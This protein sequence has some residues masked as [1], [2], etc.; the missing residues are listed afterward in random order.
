[1]N[2]N[3]TLVDYLHVLHGHSELASSCITQSVQRQ[4]FTNKPGMER[5]L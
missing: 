3:V 4:N 2:Y 1:M 5:N